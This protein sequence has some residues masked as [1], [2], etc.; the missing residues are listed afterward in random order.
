MINGTLGSKFSYVFIFVLTTHCTITFDWH[1]SYFESCVC[2]VVGGVLELLP[3]AR[4]GFGVHIIYNVGNLIIRAA[5]SIAARSCACL[6]VFCNILSEYGL[7]RHVNKLHTP[8][9]DGL[10]IF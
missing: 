5:V 8:K 6:L 1:S 7:N 10:D 3:A 4:P 9:S 2:V